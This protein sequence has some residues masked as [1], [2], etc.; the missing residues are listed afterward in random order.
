M[1]DDDHT[2]SPAPERTPRAS[3]PLHLDPMTRTSILPLPT[4]V[5]VLT[6][7]QRDIA[8]LAAMGC[9][10]TGVAVTLGVSPTYVRMRAAD[11]CA[12][13][14]LRCDRAVLA[15]WSRAYGASD[16]AGGKET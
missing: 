3:R 13:L 12:R 7:R 1:S 15:L 14:G 6:P 16:G 5:D 8:R 2:P 4:T 9:T 11:A 10:Y